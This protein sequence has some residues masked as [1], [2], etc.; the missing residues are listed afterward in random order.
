VTARRRA[1]ALPVRCA[2]AATTSSGSGQPPPNSF[3]SRP[4]F[5]LAMVA[6]STTTSN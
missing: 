2:I 5:L 6:P 4:V 1:Q 3:V